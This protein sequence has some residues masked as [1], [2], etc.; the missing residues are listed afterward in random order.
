[1]ALPC[2]TFD[3]LLPTSAFA[4]VALG[5]AAFSQLRG[6]GPQRA[7]RLALA[8]AG[9]L[10]SATVLGSNLPGGCLASPAEAPPM[11]PE[12]VTLRAVPGSSPLQLRA[13]GF[14]PKTLLRLVICAEPLPEDIRAGK[15]NG[16]EIVAFASAHCDLTEDHT[17]LTDEAGR[18]TV[19]GTAPDVAQVV[20][21]PVDCHSTP[22]Y[23][24]VAQDQPGNEAFATVAVE[25][26]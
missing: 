17:A 8:A 9:C 21:A 5:S 23:L 1:M 2:D 26:A 18:V 10:L 25:P 6:R 15:A 20:G 24:V 11:K 12:E 16:N 13:E 22:C 7:V 4:M 3:P 19:D 14:A